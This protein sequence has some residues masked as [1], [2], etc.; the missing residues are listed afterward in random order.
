M[1]AEQYSTLPSHS[2]AKLCIP[3]H[4]P[5]AIHFER[6]KHLENLV[7]KAQTPLLRITP[8]LEYIHILHCEDF[9]ILFYKF[10]YLLKI[11]SI[12]MILSLESSNKQLI[13]FHVQSVNL[14]VYMHRLRFTISNF[15]SIHKQSDIHTRGNSWFAIIFVRQRNIYLFNT[16]DLLQFT[17]SPIILANLST[18]MLQAF[19]SSKVSRGTYLTQVI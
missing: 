7:D 4:L 15:G 9:R 3:P 12:C 10:K 11:F 8:Q 14:H 18:N 17:L 2:S 13:I 16:M 19:F 6:E 1:P 5:P